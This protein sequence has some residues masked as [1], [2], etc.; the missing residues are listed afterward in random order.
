[1]GEGGRGR[2][3]EWERERGR[4]GRAKYEN[5]TTSMHSNDHTIGNYG[6]RGGGEGEQ[7]LPFQSVLFRAQQCICSVPASSGEEPH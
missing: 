6:R 7:F 2:E 3:G 4:E 1:M 5:V